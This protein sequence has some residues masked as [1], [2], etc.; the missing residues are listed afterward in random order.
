MENQS[1]ANF[2]R[3]TLLQRREQAGNQPLGIAG[4]ETPNDQFTK[5]FDR[6]RADFENDPQVQGICGMRGRK[7]GE[8]VAREQASATVT[9]QIPAIN[10]I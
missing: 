4:Q 2:P 6:D 9:G 5:I 3:A 7:T 10:A 1:L 8:Q